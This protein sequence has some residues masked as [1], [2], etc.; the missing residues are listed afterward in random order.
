M[1]PFL[2]RVLLGIAAG[3]CIYVYSG[4]AVAQ[5]AA[6]L[7]R[8][9]V[10]GAVA[11]N[12]AEFETG[13]DYLDV[14]GGAPLD[15]SIWRAGG[16][17]GDSHR[18]QATRWKVGSVYRGVTTQPVTIIGG[19]GYLSGAGFSSALDVS[20]ETLSYTW[21]LSKD[22]E[23][24]FGVG[25][26]ASRIRIDSDVTVIVAGFPGDFEINSSANERVTLPL[27]RGEYVRLIGAWR[28]GAETSVGWKTG[29]DVRARS[30]EASVSLEYLP[31][32]VVAVG[33]RYSIHRT[34]LESGSQAW[35]GMSSSEAETGALRVRSATPQLYITL[36]Y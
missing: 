25:L 27:V 26:G 28:I 1:C 16:T 14:A 30:A 36:R 8:V 24:A 3:S 32:P 11:V 12:T 5:Q 23:Q 13:Q 22:A 4:V 6:V 2:P 34:K 19:I 10:S 20:V 33:V 9:F 18:F 31:A 35:L 21:F 15:E 7:D 17:V 29:K